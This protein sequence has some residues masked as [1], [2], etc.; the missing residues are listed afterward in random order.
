MSKSPFDNNKLQEITTIRISSVFVMRDPAMRAAAVTMAQQAAYELHHRLMALGD[1]RASTVVE[2]RDGI[3]AWEKEE[4]RQP[5]E[6]IDYD[7]VSLGEAIARIPQFDYS[8]PA[9]TRQVIDRIQMEHEDPGFVP[10]K[11][12]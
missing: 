7:V 9:N 10:R 11:E 8:E 6:G 2:H 12:D 3:E 1:Q 4:I 5:D